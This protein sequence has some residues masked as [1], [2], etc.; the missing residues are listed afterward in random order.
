MQLMLRNWMILK[1]MKW[2]TV[3][4]KTITAMRWTTIM[5][6]GRSNSNWIQERLNLVV[7]IMNN[8]E[9]N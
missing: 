1:L 2:R 9:H 4:T 5:I 6:N 7:I 8:E 3:I